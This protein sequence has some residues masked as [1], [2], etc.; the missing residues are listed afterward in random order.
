MTPQSVD[1]HAEAERIMIDLVRKAPMSKR[2]RLVQSLTQSAR[3]SSLRA[4]REC[5]PGADEQQAAIG[6]VSCSYGSTFA[7]LVQAALERRQGWHIQPTDLVSVMLPALEV[8]DELG[9]TGYLGGSVAS[10]LHGMQQLAQ[11]VDLVVDLPRHRLPSL[12]ALLGQ[13]YVLGEE[14]AR[15]AARERAAFPVIHLDS[16]LKVD[17]VLP[18]PSA[19]EATMRRLVAPATLD[20]RCPPVRIASAPEMILVKLRRYQRDERSR[21]DGMRDDAQWNDIVGMLKVQGL[22]LDLVLLEQ[23]AE[24]LEVAETW[25]WALVAAGLADA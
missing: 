1:T 20:E 13:H 12:L 19:F 22:D 8:F 23:W 16:L 18:R 2:F 25:R 24:A 7:R 4:W 14:E 10:S 3:W 5:H 17:V 11:D 9:A 6:Y 15:Q 21:S